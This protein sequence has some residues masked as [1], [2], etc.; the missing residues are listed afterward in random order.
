MDINQRMGFTA[1]QT[2]LLDA[3]LSGDNVK[4]RQ[5]GGNMKLSYLEGWKAI[6]E[7]NRIFGFDGWSRET[8]EL[9][10]NTPPTKTEKGNTVVSFRAKVRVTA[11][12]VVREGTGYGD[13]NDKNIHAAYELAIKEAETDAMKRALMTFGHPFGLALYDKTQENV[14][15]PAGGGMKREEIE[16]KV[17][18]ATTRKELNLLK[19]S[20]QIPA[21]DK[22]WAIELITKKSA[23]L[24]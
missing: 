23:T 2:A 8:V 10:E 24:A 14:D 3:K 19:A 6:E 22:A 13:G 9:I 18:A 5:G 20:D 17:N 11:G 4:T 7:A 16:A 15:G 12:G 21:E 1:E